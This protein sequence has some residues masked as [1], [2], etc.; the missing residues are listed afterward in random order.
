MALRRFFASESPVFLHRDGHVYPDR[1]QCVSMCGQEV[2]TNKKD[3]WKNV[4]AVKGTEFDPGEIG[5]EKC[6]EVVMAAAGKD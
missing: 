2:L 1:R 4:K 3:D 5:C 6:R